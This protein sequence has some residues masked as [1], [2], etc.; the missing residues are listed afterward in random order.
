VWWCADGCHAAVFLALVFSRAVSAADIARNKL[1]LSLSLSVVR[2][3]AHSLARS[4]VLCLFSHALDPPFGVVPNTTPLHT[5]LPPPLYADVTSIAL[6]VP[7]SHLCCEQGG[8]SSS[9]SEH[10]GGERKRDGI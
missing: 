1:S 6:D 5:P 3:F 2:L 8:H 10:E 7:S 9:S 4:L